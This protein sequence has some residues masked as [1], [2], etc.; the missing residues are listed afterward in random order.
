MNVKSFA[1]AAGI[2]AIAGSVGGASTHIGT[3]L[4]KGLTDVSQAITRITVQA[5]A[6]AATD[7]SLQFIEKG[8]VDTRQLLLNT[9]G[10]LTVAATSEITQNYSKQN[11]HQIKKSNNELKQDREQ[12]NFMS[13]KDIEAIMNKIHDSNKSLR[14]E[15]N[16]KRQSRL[17][18]KIDHPETHGIKS[19]RRREKLKTDFINSP[20]YCSYFSRRINLTE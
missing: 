6:A 4:S 10:Q 3:N 7:A 9:A 8:D 5:S 14:N 11:D 20:E 15:E 13:P 12:F 19:T 2:G 16:L 17:R 18:K 1:K